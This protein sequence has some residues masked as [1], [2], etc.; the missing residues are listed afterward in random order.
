MENR[1]LGIRTTGDGS[2]TCYSDR[3]KQHYH[4]V[5]GARTE[6]EKVYLDLGYAL[7]AE[8]FARIELLEVGFGT[9]LNAYLTA[10]ASE[11]VPTFYTGLEA[12]PIEEEEWRQFPEYLRVL[13][14]LSWEEEHT[15][16]PLFNVIKLRTKLED[17]L[18]DKRFHLVYYDAFS[19]EAQPELWT[20]ERFAQVYGW[21]EA[22]GILCTYCSKVLVQKNLKSAGF[23]VEKHPGPP[24]K[25]EVIRAIK[26]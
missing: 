25:R 22:G 8:R 11:K 7:A 3:F 12:F 15:I 24:H 21:M 23:E 1:D 5:H 17:F 4:S 19:P 6:S 26:K 13:H 2:I 10:L 16:H 14:G 9:G 18:P 20:S